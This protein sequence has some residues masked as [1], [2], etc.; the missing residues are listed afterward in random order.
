MSLLRD[1]KEGKKGEK[2]MMFLKWERLTVLI[3]LVTIFVT[4][5]AVAAD[6][7]NIVV[8]DPLS[9]TMKD[10]G[11]RTVWGLQFA[12]DET[13][14]AGGLLGKQIKLM[15][16]DSQMKPDVAARKAV[17]AIMEDKAQ[18]IFHLTSTAVAQALM[19]V[20]EK[21]KVIYT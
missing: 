19:D 2:K 16:E 5:Q 21:N 7:V 10:I 14:A 12:V 8:I 20:A 9:G 6:T 4:G 18:F 1:K 3:F 11:D 17:R 15:P 13:N